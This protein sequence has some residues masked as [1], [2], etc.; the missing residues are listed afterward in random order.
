[1]RSLVV[2]NRPAFF[3]T[4]IRFLHFQ[5]RSL[6]EWIFL[7]HLKFNMQERMPGP[8]EFQ[9]LSSQLRADIPCRFGKV[10]MDF[11]A[12]SQIQRWKLDASWRSRAWGES[13]M[14]FDLPIADGWL[15]GKDLEV[16]VVSKIYQNLLSY[17][18]V[19]SHFYE[20]E[21][22]LIL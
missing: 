5:V 10:Q 7:G 8:C 1:M 15:E 4:R 6:P 22:K 19:S 18:Q 2:S 11:G 16:G 17:H 21:R 20:L 12:R 3:E 13:F 14:G 9:S